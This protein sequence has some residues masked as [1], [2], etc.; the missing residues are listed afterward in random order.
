MW[1]VIRSVESIYYS[2]SVNLTYVTFPAVRL[3]GELQG[4]LFYYA[5]IA[6]TPPPR[7]PQSIHP[8][9]SHCVYLSPFSLCLCDVCSQIPSSG[10]RCRRSGKSSLDGTGWQRT[11][12]R[13][14]P[15]L[16]RHMRRSLSLRLNN[17]HVK[18]C[19][20]MPLMERYR[21]L[22]PIQHK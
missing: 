6:H 15:P 8:P 9:S 22:Q 3:D 14:F 19:L 10:I 21:Y 5:L 11:S 7:L 2:R 17:Q 4:L 20:L 13:R 12:S 18:K 1:R 16:S